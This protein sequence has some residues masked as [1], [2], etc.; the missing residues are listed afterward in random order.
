MD[1]AGVASLL[2]GGAIVKRREKTGGIAL[3]GGAWA[4][5]LAGVASANSVTDTHRFRLGY[6]DQDV[7]L[8]ASI[9]RSP[10]PEVKVDFDR[11]LGLDESSHSGFFSYQWR[12]GEKWALQG[13]YSRME[14]S[15]EKLATRDFNFDGQDYKAGVLLESEFDL[16]TYLVAVNYSF[17]RDDRKE[18]GLGAG[19]HAFDI[20]TTIGAAVRVEGVTESGVRNNATLLAPLPNL[21]FFGTYMITPRWEISLS[22][23]WLSITYD[24]YDGDYLFLTAFTEYRFTERFGIGL[25]YQSA[26]ID[27][28][29][30]DRKTRKEFEIDISGPSIFLT[31]G[32]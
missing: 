22:G 25:S 18:F 15:G 24:D 30:E 27:A 16:D 26:D 21:R 19:L 1:R 31:Y 8:N 5:A 9:T 20:D 11:V 2:Q 4:L 13:F 17:L 3:L 10:Q 6:Y 7:D 14:A 29:V 28:T 32:F 12:F 23:G